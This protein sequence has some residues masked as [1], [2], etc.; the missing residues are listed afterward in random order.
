MTFP[1]FPWS[2][3]PCK[4]LTIGDAILPRCVT[5]RC[6][7]GS[8]SAQRRD[9]EELCGYRAVT[10]SFVPLP[11]RSA[12][13][14]RTS[15]PMKA[16]RTAKRPNIT[17]IS[18]RLGGQSGKSA[19][20]IASSQLPLLTTRLT[21]QV[22]AWWRGHTCSIRLIFWAIKVVSEL[23]WLLTWLRIDMS[24]SGSLAFFSRHRSTAN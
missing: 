15:S 9:T 18:L 10:G 19:R 13:S 24:V 5:V 11:S 22:N 20:R 8:G 23:L 4:R 2:Y 7:C 3:E 17:L 16:P 21:S 14:E 6:P 1:G 12:T